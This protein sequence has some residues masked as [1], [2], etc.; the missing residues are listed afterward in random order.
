MNQPPSNLDSIIQQSVG[1]ATPTCQMPT[2]P[3]RGSM[4]I[5]AN[6]D[7]SA[8]SRLTSA[9][10]FEGLSKILREFAYMNGSTDVVASMVEAAPRMAEQIPDAAIDAYLGRYGDKMMK[11]L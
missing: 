9:M 1:V 10:G 3:N 8:L 7:L 6:Q 5:P 4:V 2:L 11:F